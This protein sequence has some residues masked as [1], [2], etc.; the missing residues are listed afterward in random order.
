VIAAVVAGC[1]GDSSKPIRG[2]LE[3]TLTDTPV[4]HPVPGGFVGLS[5][6]FPAVIGYAGS[7]PAQID[8]VFAQLIRNISPRGGP[9][10]RVGGDSSDR[11]W[12]PVPGML[13]PGG[14]TYNLTNRWAHVA[15]A[16]ARAV[17]AR[18]VLDINM[19]ADSP[20]LSAY[21]AR[22]LVGG[23]G[24]RRI[25]ALELGNE[26]ELYGVFPLYQ[27]NGYPVKGR[28]PNYSPADYTREFKQVAAAMPP[29]PLAGPATGAPQWEAKL[30]QFVGAV[31]HLSLLTVHRY[32][33]RGCFTSPRS[34]E[35]HSIRNLLTRRATHGLAESIKPYLSLR[36][37]GR[38]LVRVDELNSVN[39]G[40]VRGVSDTFASALWSLDTLFQ[41]VRT[42]VSGVNFHT[43][44]GARYA[45]FT[46]R[47]RHGTWLGT[48]RPLYYGILMFARAAPA[49]SHLLKGSGR[50]ANG[51]DVWGVRTPQG[52]VRAVI[53]NYNRRT[54][55]TV[56]LSLPGST[57]QATVVRLQASG[58]AA[59][60]GVSIGG[61]SFADPT[62][63]G[64]LSGA[65]SLPTVRSSQQGYVV[66]VPP[67]SAAL[68]TP[69][70]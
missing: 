8:P 65:E 40:G 16:L 61:R 42:G 13:R 69:T 47:R 3:I 14:I 11:T 34:P 7:D 4:G 17:G 21:E 51:L 26:P 59:R 52:S 64:R 67:A 60:T 31:P 49:G 10:L 30:H 29:L 44:P 39:C 38:P 6:E 53:I 37:S 18:I 55:R 9:G 2:V 56:G 28:P 5:L 70:S 58:A 48:V 68:V 43:F 33:T 1:G 27:R 32:A 24:A 54:S 50:F 41:L 20:Q 46:F 63:T 35:Y 19:E 36:S 23:I 12:W 22:Q 25:R 15:R 62:T 66:H 45:P 57:G